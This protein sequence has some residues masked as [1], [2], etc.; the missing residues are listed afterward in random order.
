MIGVHIQ[1]GKIAEGQMLWV[2]PAGFG[3]LPIISPSIYDAGYFQHYRRICETPVAK[4]LNRFRV[5]LMRDALDLAAD[6]PPQ[7]VLDVGIGDG[8]FLRAAAAQVPFGLVELKGCDIN[9]LGVEYLE[10]HGQLAHLDDEGGFDVVCF[11]DVLEHL[12]DPRV[13][14]RASRKTALVSIPIFES[15]LHALRSRHFK[16][17]EHIWYFTRRGFLAFA[18][19]E[20]FDCV[21]ILA[22][23]S[24]IGRDGIETFVLRRR[25]A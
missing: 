7:T 22:T 25:P 2:E 23:E 9:P 5:G 8:A 17:G 18:D 14:L 4:A 1:I 20:G 10:Q 24:A 16:P 12:P 15:Q 11:W 3:Y 13:G 6:A 21:D 19:Q